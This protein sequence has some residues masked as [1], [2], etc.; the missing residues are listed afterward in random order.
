MVLEA[1]GHRV[2][3]T[4]DA[5]AA[6]EAA[7]ARKFDLFILDIGLP[8]MDGVELAGYLRSSGRA[9]AAMIVALTGY[10]AAR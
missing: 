8:G 1:E 9:G 7:A 4:H 5:G 2:Q 6:L 10:G 3:L